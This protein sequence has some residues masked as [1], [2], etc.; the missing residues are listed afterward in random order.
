ML[1]KS[2]VILAML[3]CSMATQVFALGLG[4][5]TVESALNQPLRVRIEIIQLGDT[6]LDDVTVQMAALADFQR[7]NIDRVGFLSDIRFRIEGTDQGDY[8][9][10]TSNQIVREPYLSFILDTRWPNGRLLSEHTVLLD[11]PAFSNQSQPSTPVQQPVSPI[12][13]TPEPA[14]PV[15][16]E[17]ERTPTPPPEVP[18]PDAAAV[19]EP[20]PEQVEPEAASEPEVAPAAAEDEPA[21]NDMPDSP[22]TAA[23]DADAAAD[24]NATIESP[25]PAQAPAPAAAP[26][27][28]QADAGE[29]AIVATEPEEPAGPE[30]LE[31]SPNDTLTDIALQ[32]RPDNSVSLQ[33]TMLAIQRLNP[34]A[35][36]EGNINRMRSGEV[37]RV[38]QL[39]DVQEITAAEA[40]SEINRQNQ[41][42]ADLQPLTAIADAQQ[43][44]SAEPQGELSVVTDTG[45]SDGNGSVA[46]DAELEE[47]DQRIADLEN[48]LA[49]QQEE[50]DRAR[51]QREEL[52]SRMSELD[53]QIAAAQEIIRLQDL[54][55]AQLQE[56]L[57]EA[58]AEAEAQAAAEAA[59]Q[60]AI[61]AAEAEAQQAARSGGIV[62]DIMRIMSGNTMMMV[63]A[64]VLVILLLV[65]LLLRRNRADKVTSNDELDELAEQEFDAASEEVSDA[66]VVTKS[67]PLVDEELTKD[68]LDSELDDIISAS[69]GDNDFDLDLDSDDDEDVTGEADEL[70]AAAKFGEANAM[71]R[72]ALDDDPDNAETRL[73]L[74]EVLVK[75]NDKAGFEEQAALIAAA[76][77][78]DLDIVVASLR[79]QF[80]SDAT[81]A[82]ADFATE[83]VETDS[84]LDDLGID[85]DAFDDDDL[86]LA[87][88]NEAPKA[89]ADKDTDKEPIAD[90][91]QPSAETD[92][93]A[94]ADDSGP[95]DDDEF[96]LS[97]DLSGDDEQS[98]AVPA[99]NDSDDDLDIDLDDGDNLD[100]NADNSEAAEL[101]SG[102][103]KDI[104]ELEIETF[105]FELDTADD[106]SVKDDSASDSDELEIETFEF[107]AD[108]ADATQST[109]AQESGRDEPVAGDENSVEF[110]F[111][112]DSDDSDAAKPKDESEVATD[113]L[114]TFDFDLEDTFIDK[115]QSNDDSA[116]TESNENEVSFELDA[117]DS[118]APEASAKPDES[119]DFDFDLGEFEIDESEAEDASDADKPVASATKNSDEPDE[120][121][122]LDAVEDVSEVGESKP[123]SSKATDSS[124]ELEDL[125]FLADDDDLDISD[126]EL[127]SDDDE[128][129][130][131]LELA[132]AY[133]KMGDAEG[134]R[135]ILKEVLKEGNADQVKEAEKLLTS[136]DLE[137]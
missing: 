53:E 40:I 35:F 79:E 96:E 29:E 68:E 124:D 77:R 54:Q 75:Q 69:N 118:P 123:E 95:E 98:S 48:T 131:K 2:V 43:A 76:E 133:Q 55:L 24:A 66:R 19:A 81:E 17:P 7:F 132:Y 14:P 11:L 18:A 135:E 25:A 105:D 80:A 71:L 21:A 61:A 37:L 3:M 6:R 63:F 115:P 102:D 108:E 83:D 27:D 33:Q 112:L 52:E 4:T 114:E 8:V 129:A 109:P 113:D 106:E 97:F 127:L 107:N 45:D 9:V 41:Q 126:V 26:A 44:D 93:F 60:A 125:D 122:D 57:A 116:T 82:G 16:T 47:L 87:A 130:T 134:A 1:R 89:D 56:S 117:D 39:T 38:P 86:D 22:A 91:A 101:A 59:Q 12:V 42:F 46:D 34:D 94:E 32:V 15:I 49:L 111:D 50:A 65:V 73:K 90:Q 10:L 28:S 104:D 36:I 121:F 119:D 70:I 5:V 64:V 99:N 84:F 31:T 62:N 103:S 88:T 67:D 100:S 136:I 30:T 85:L 74:A 72:G 92:E 51:L 128:A 110:A 20:A 78:P 137:S 120:F 23:A 58:A 13:R